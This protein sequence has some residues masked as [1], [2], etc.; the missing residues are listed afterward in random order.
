MTLHSTATHILHHNALMALIR[1][2]PPA[3]N[4]QELPPPDTWVKTRQL[5]DALGISIYKA[6]R[7]M[8]DLTAHDLAI[9]SS[10]TINKSLHWYPQNIPSSL[11]SS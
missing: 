4:N 9:V 10:G 8:H 6:R 1:L 11:R 7:I 3:P 5:A 2:A